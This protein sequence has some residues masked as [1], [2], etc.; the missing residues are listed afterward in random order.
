[1]RMMLEVNV[2]ELK[3]G[4]VLAKAVKNHHGLTMLEAGTKLK[5]TYIEKLTRLGIR[6]VLIRTEQRRGDAD[7]GQLAGSLLFTAGREEK[8][9]ELEKQAAVYRYVNEFAVSPKMLRRS[10]IPELDLKFQVTFRNYLSELIMHPFILKTLSKLYWTDRYLFDHSLNVAVLSGIIGMA[11]NFDDKK[12]GALIAGA[13][14]FDAGMTLLPREIVQNNRLLSPQEKELIGS[15]TTEGYNLLKSCV[16]ISEST[17]RC[18]LEHHERYDGSG[19]PVGLAGKNIHEFAQIIAIADVYDALISP[20][21]YRKPY[22]LNEATEFL[23]ASGNSLF[24]I[25]LVRL[26]LKHIAIYPISTIVRLNN[27]QVGV[28]VTV[29]PGLAH[30]PVVKILR[31]ADGSPPL[32]PYHV[33]LLKQNNLVISYVYNDQGNSPI[34]PGGYL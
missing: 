31:E 22:T 12:L 13:L 5:K 21:P 30:R 27:G 20:R 11:K 29:R 33:D 32:A 8:K 10:S 2:S 26:F 18:A 17:A 16:D 15:H 24:D 1:M 25:E 9:E 14:L 4:D 19:Y 7:P 23:Y 28:V 3:D 6:K 34:N